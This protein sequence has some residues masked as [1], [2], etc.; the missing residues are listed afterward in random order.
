MAAGPSSSAGPDV[1]QLKDADEEYEAGM[2]SLQVQTPVI[3]ASPGEV[4]SLFDMLAGLAM[5]PCVQ[6][7]DL[8]KAVELLGAALQTRIQAH[9]GGTFLFAS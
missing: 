2:A 3:I 1:Q 6:A 8:D 5:L 7:N 9:G 4:P